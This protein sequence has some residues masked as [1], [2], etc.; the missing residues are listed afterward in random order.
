LQ[1]VPDLFERENVLAATSEFESSLNPI[2]EA[3][4]RTLSLLAISRIQ[5][6]YDRT[7]QAANVFENQIVPTIEEPGFRSS[8]ERGLKEVSY[9]LVDANQA[10][11]LALQTYQQFDAEKRSSSSEIYQ[12]VIEH[13]DISYTNIIQA[14]N[15]LTELDKGI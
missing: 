9:R 6:V 4:Y 13:L 15:F 2:S 10:I 11:A 3:Q 7:T 8:T 5:H 14:L 12:R 1:I